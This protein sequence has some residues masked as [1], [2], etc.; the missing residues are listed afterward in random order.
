MGTGRSGRGLVRPESLGVPRE[1][2]DRT[3]R[4]PAARPET[5]AAPDSVP[6]E[7][8][9]QGGRIVAFYAAEADEIAP[10]LPARAFCGLRAVRIA[11]LYSQRDPRRARPRRRPGRGRPA[12]RSRT[13]SSWAGYTSATPASGGWH[14]TPSWKEGRRTDRSSASDNR[15]RQPSSLSTSEKGPWRVNAG[16]LQGLSPGTVLSVHRVAGRGDGEVL[17]HVEVVP[18]GFLPLASRV[19]P[20]VRPTPLRRLARPGPMPPRLPP[21]RRRPAPDRRRLPQR[22]CGRRTVPRRPPPPERGPDGTGGIL[23]PRA[24]QTGRGG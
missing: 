12:T 7:L 4:P 16:S 20:C 8:P 23:R 19:V 10:E 18:E 17:G 11:H 5:A 24:G 21:L 13:G 9:G 22:A 3:R 6:I 14:R 15:T 2:R 1:A